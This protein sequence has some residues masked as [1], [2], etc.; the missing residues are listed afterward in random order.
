VHWVLDMSFL[1]SEESLLSGRVL[2]SSSSEASY[3]NWS[4]AVFLIFCK[5]IEWLDFEP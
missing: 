5:S 1:T 2:R 4:W 3:W